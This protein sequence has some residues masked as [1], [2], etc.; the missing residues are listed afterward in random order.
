VAAEAGPSESLL[1]VTRRI[2]EYFASAALLPP[3]HAPDPPVPADEEVWGPPPD[4][5]SDPP[6]GKDAW[7]ADLPG[8]LLDEYLEATAG[9]SVAEALPAGRRLGA[10]VNGPGFASGGPADQLEPGAVLAGL[11]A[12]AWRDGLGQLSDD[13]LIGVMRA[14]R[15]LASWAAA[16]ELAALAELEHRRTS[17]VAAGG[18]PHLLE[19]LEE[20]IAAPLTLTARAAGRLLG[21]ATGLNRLPATRAALAAGL[22]DTA[23]AYTLVDEVTGLDDAH[24]GKVEATVI[25]KAPQQTTGQ[26]RRAAHRAVLAA[27]PGAAK[28]RY[29][30]ARLDA[31]VELWQEP[32][33]TAALAGR[34]LHAADAIAADRRID[35]LARRLKHTGAEETLPQLRARVF[36][37]LLLGQP[38]G[39][40]SGAGKQDSGEDREER[41]G[42][43]AAPLRGRVN[44]TMPLATWLGASEAPGEV[45]GYGPLPAA[46]ARALA[47]QLSTSRWCLTLLDRGG[48]AIAHGCSTAPAKGPVQPTTRPP[49]TAAS[50]ISSRAGATSARAGSVVGDTGP[51]PG[52]E[53][54]I[55]L[56]SLAAGEC[57]H[58][59]ESAGYVP[60]ARLRHLVRIRQRTCT[61]PGCRRSADPCD[62]DH[63]VPYANGGRTCECNLAPTCNI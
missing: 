48:G 25:A 14:W 40:S 57:D 46:D 36:T 45:A 19:H 34:D 58:R 62:L 54:T 60:S 13:E 3:D 20:E 16:G 10:S 49:G 15:R 21:F 29:D 9:P 31:R 11:T 63:T 18:D 28:R 12:G 4:P 37:A 8:D 56:A 33:G 47:K 51:P 1:S 26:L 39:V 61:A 35:G 55:K 24:A 41:S 50:Q 44:L 17:Q 53:L 5:Y 7:L 27:D 38:I 43:A 30:Q 59:H 32:A 2:R 42:S 23:K 6:D 22:I 52:W